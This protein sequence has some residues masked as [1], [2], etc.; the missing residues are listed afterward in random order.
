MT[1]LAITDEFGVGWVPYFIMGV[2]RVAF[3][4]VPGK[5]G[6]RADMVGVVI[7]LDLSSIPEVPHEIAELIMMVESGWM[8][9]FGRIHGIGGPCHDPLIPVA[10]LANKRGRAYDL[11]RKLR[12]ASK[13]ADGG[14]QT[15]IVTGGAIFRIIPSGRFM[16]PPVNPL[17]DAFP[18]VATGRSC[19][20]DAVPVY[21]HAGGVGND[22]MTGLAKPVPG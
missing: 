12:K 3:F 16:V 8:A 20:Y 11:R 10:I 18:T 22:V 15:G 7:R 19:V 14:D 17:Q 1:D 6:S 2:G 13:F 5:I 4:A 21:Q 9:C